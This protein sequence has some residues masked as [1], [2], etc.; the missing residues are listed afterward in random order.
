[1][2]SPKQVQFAENGHVVI[3]EVS[4]HG[5]VQKPE[6]DTVKVASTPKKPKDTSPSNRPRGE[7]LWRVPFLI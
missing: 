4:Y 5:I 2:S 1:M 6:K 7:G 3:A